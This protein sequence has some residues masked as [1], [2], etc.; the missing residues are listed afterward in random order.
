MLD[1]VSQ[2]RAGTAMMRFST[3]LS[4]DDIA[5][6]VDFIRTTFMTRAAY[7][8]RYHTPENG[9][10]N[11]EQYREAF[12]FVLGELSLTTPVEELTPAQRRGRRLFFATC[13]T[14]HEPSRDDE[15]ASVW[16]PRPLSYPRNGVTPQNLEQN[17]GISGASPFA[18]HNRA[19]D[20]SLLSEI[21]RHGGELF[22]DNCAF[23]HGADG[24]GRNWI[25]Q[26]IEPKARDLRGAADLAALDD[27]A[28]SQIIR[29]GKAG[30]AM[31]AWKYVL[32]DEEIGAIVVFLRET[33][34]VEGNKVL[35]K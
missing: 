22:R 25:G 1:T 28:L 23:C 16:Q 12:P 34:F 7:N 19:P 27:V 35:N 10:A 20:L 11:H 4:E 9:W 3:Q 18:M 8:T 32:G 13:I 21:A 31:P 17:D 15:A 30:S 5:A 29:E 26:F 33:F 14:C 24:S 6:V 2:G